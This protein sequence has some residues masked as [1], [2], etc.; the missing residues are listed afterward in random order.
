MRKKSIPKLREVVA[1]TKTKIYCQGMICWK[2]DFTAL[3]TVKL[4][5]TKFGNQAKPLI[6]SEKKSCIS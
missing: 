6:Y 3:W 1:G 4:G 2:C 5:L